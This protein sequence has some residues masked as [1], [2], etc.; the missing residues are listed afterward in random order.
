MFQGRTIDGYQTDKQTGREARNSAAELRALAA[1]PPDT[2][3]RQ[4][5]LNPRKLKERMP[6]AEPAAGQAQPHFV[7]WPWV[8][9][10]ALPE[11]VLEA[12]APGGTKLR[13]HLKATATLQA[14]ALGR[15]LWRDEG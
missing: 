15:M 1:E 9:G 12:E 2:T 5:R 11:C 8:E 7:E 6:A 14:A 4:L 13:I 10:T 3:A